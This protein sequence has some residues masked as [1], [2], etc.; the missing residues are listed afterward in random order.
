MKELLPGSQYY[1]KKILRNTFTLSP[2]I[3]Y[4]ISQGKIK[5]DMISGEAKKK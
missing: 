2:Q 1:Y 4:E 5:G 3:R